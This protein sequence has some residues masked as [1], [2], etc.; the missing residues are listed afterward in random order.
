MAV[1]FG[2]ARTTTKGTALER[3]PQLRY[4]GPRDPLYLTPDQYFD[5][6]CDVGFVSR[7]NFSPKANSMRGCVGMFRGRPVIVDE[8]AP[9]LTWRDEPSVI[10]EGNRLNSLGAALVIISG[11]LLLWRILAFFGLM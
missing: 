10:D 5:L 1:R 7:A 6:I 2:L 9:R 8:G 11:A 4:G 3:Y